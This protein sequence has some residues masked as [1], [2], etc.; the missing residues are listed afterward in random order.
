MDAEEKLEAVQIDAWLNENHFRIVAA[1]NPPMNTFDHLILEQAITERTVVLGDF[2]AQ[3]TR[4]GYPRTSPVGN[5]MELLIDN[6]SL[7]PIDT[8]PTFLSF[9]GHLG[10]P[11]LILP[12]ANLS[13][14]C[15]HQLLDDP[16]G[17]RHRIIVVTIVPKTKVPKKKAKWHDYAEETD[18]MCIRDRSFFVISPSICN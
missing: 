18:K 16:S 2:N 15:R 13:N 11:D 5:I 3:S 10:R 9:A 12:H 17:C 1:Y 8:E 6:S 7:I 14:R 4:W